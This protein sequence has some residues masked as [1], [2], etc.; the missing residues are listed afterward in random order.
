MKWDDGNDHIE[1]LER[2]AAFILLTGAGHSEGQ[3]I[4]N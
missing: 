3:S 1:D 2:I 4:D